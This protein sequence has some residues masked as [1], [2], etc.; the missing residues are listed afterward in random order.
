MEKC[1][2]GH[3]LR[4]ATPIVPG[5]Q[6]TAE[7]HRFEDIA[8]TAAHSG[9]RDLELTGDIDVVLTAGDTHGDLTLTPRRSPSQG[10]RCPGLPGG[11]ISNRAQ[12]R[13]CE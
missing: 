9:R 10:Q 4:G 11:L 13:T 5:L 6:V 3:D 12:K 2:C 1:T 7:S 8:D